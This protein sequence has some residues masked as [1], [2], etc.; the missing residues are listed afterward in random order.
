VTPA[1]A[2]SRPVTVLTPGADSGTDG[3]VPS[4]SVPGPSTRRRSRNHRGHAVLGRLVAIGALAV[5]LAACGGS[6]STATTT[7]VTPATTSPTT[8]GGGASTSSSTTSSTAAGPQ[9]C[10]TAS[11]TVSLGSPN[12]SAGATHYGLTFR[13]TGTAACTLYGYPGVSFLGASGQQIGDPAQRQG[14]TPTTVTLAAGGSAYASV[15][16]TDPGIPPCSG[17]TAA[18]QLRVYP[19]GETQAAVVTAPSGLLVCSSPNTSTY[20]SSIVSPVT[21]TTA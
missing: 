10:R 7:T 9:T 5:G 15:V 12:G 20:L 16:V 8:T 19:P 2:G 17:S 14:G 13:N 21:T 18:T 1:R 4:P 3:E 11:L 6:N